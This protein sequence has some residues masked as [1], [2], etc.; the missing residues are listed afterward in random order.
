[1]ITR[2]NDRT[3]LTDGGEPVRN[4]DRWRV[5]AVGHDGRL[6]VAHVAGHGEVVLPADYVCSHVRL[7]YA[8]TAH[9][10]QGDTVDVGIAIVTSATTHR[11]L[12]V[13]AT[14]GRHENRFLVV[15]DEPDMAEARD[16]LEQVLTNERVD[17]PAVVQRRNLG[18]QQPRTKQATQD[19]PDRSA[20]TPPTTRS[21]RVTKQASVQA[22]EQTLAAAHRALDDARRL[23]QPVL[24][25]VREAETA[26]RA[27]DDALRTRRAIVAEAAP[28]RRRGAALSARQAAVTLDHAR[29]RLD[30]SKREAASYVNRIEVA[31]DRVHEAERG[32]RAAR[33]RERLERM[34]APDIARQGRDRGIVLDGLGL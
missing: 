17:I 4:R 12:Y 5:A 20:T 18:T 21:R 31:A 3:L 29:S 30:D 19:T 28:W 33:S 34:R 32:V 15:T 9:G 7:G 8:A 1:M 10:H 26:E 11:S 14:R 23:A 16:V 22:A 2:R 25:S 13:G 6:A 24:R 27:A